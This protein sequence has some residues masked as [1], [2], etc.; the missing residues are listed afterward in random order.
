MVGARILHGARGA[1]GQRLRNLW[2]ERFGTALRWR[3]GGREEVGDHGL[4][5][6]EDLAQFGGDEGC[7]GGRGGRAGGDLVRGV[8]DVEGRFVGLEDSGCG[9]PW[10]EADEEGDL[11]L[12]LRC[13]VGGCIEGGRWGRR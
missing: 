4:L 6:G 12:F 13:G 2:S 8:V 5:L 3:G 1:P 9:L 10:E 11:F 7:E